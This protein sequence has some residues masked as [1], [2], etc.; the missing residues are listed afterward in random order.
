MRRGPVSGTRGAWQQTHNQQHRKRIPTLSDKP[1]PGTGRYYT[2]YR[3][4]GGSARRQRFTKD[5]K[6]SEQLYRRWVIE[7]YNDSVDIIIRDGSGFNGTLERTLPY[8][9]N[10]LVQ[11][12]EGRVRPDGSPRTGGTIS[13]RVFH[14]NRHQVVNILKW[15]K[16]R[17]GDRLKQN[18]S[19]DLLTET[20]YETMIL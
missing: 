6:E 12:D 18:S 14:D 5:R 20:D 17:F 1:E 8:I 9:S 13:L 11:H 10:A 19:R 15:C 16:E 7:H 2:S 3:A 4:A